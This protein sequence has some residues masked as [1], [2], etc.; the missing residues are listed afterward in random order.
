[1][2]KICNDVKYHSLMFDCSLSLLSMINNDTKIIH[3]SRMWRREWRRR[4]MC[5]GVHKPFKLA[6][7][8]G[9]PKSAPKAN[10]WKCKP[11]T[12]FKHALFLYRAVLVFGIETLFRGNPLRRIQRWYRKHMNHSIWTTSCPRAAGRKFCALKWTRKPNLHIFKPYWN[13]FMS[14]PRVCYGVNLVGWGSFLMELQAWDWL[15]DIVN[16][17]LFSDFW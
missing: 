7:K 16:L 3:S 2:E 8:R 10:F 14:I 13:Q 5:C 1:M 4:L 11:G 9:V 6:L 17:P 12:N 15:A